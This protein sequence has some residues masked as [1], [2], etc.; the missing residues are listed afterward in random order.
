M[1][2]VFKSGPIDTMITA[3]ANFT[4]IAK[5]MSFFEKMPLH[6]RNFEIVFLRDS[7]FA[8]VELS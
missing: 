7:L 4:A 2:F 3:A 6:F 8:L 5:T 1:H